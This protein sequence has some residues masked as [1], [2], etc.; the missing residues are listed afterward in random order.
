[1]SFSRTN[2]LED[3]PFCNR[4]SI[5]TPTKMVEPVTALPYHSI[6]FQPTFNV[7]SSGGNFS[8]APGSSV[9]KEPLNR[10]E[11]EKIKENLT[12]RYGHKPHIL[13]RRLKSLYHT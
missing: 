8:G 4:P 1:M 6:S 11:Y 9:R 2:F 13:K 12:K 7:T 5:T 3:F 10:D